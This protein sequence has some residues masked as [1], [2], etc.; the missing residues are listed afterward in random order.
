MTQEPHR[1]QHYD[2]CIVGA[3]IGGLNALY[4]A[5][6]YLRP[7]QRV[8]LVD[9]NE[10]VGGMWVNT[11]DYVRLHQP[12]PFFTTG[13]VQWTLGKEPAHLASKP[14]V[15]DHF[16]HCVAEARK[17][18]GVD[19]LLGHEM[20]SIEEVGD[21]V[22]VSCRVLADGSRVT[23][24]ADKVINAMALDIEA[25]Q[26]LALSSTHVHSVSPET[27]DMVA[28]PI[29]QD[30]APVWVIGS[31]KTAMDTA[32]ALITAQPGREV[33]L[34]AGTGT[35]FLERD[36]FYPVGRNRWWKGTRPN[37]LLVGVT[38]RLDGHNELE[39]FGWVRDT[40][41][42]CA[43]PMGEHF[44]LGVLSRSETDRIRNGL[45]RV[46]MGHLEDVVDDH[47]AVRLRLRS[48][49]QVTI[50]DGSW[51]VNC[52]SHFKHRPER[53]HVPYV[54]ES[55]R[56]VTLGI[57]AMFGFSSFAGYF[58]THLL[59]TGK[60][61]EVPLY[62]VDANALMARSAPALVASALLQSQYNLGLAFDALPAKVFQHFGLDFDRWYP[63]P[64]RLVGQVQFMVRHKK[65]REQY[66]RALDT[67]VARWDV[68][69]G[70]VVGGDQRA[71]PHS[72]AA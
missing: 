38:D 12:H 50:A 22:Q 52:T 4:V 49:E 63:L 30:S 29:S 3:G 23:I 27:C 41:G 24:T 40:V 10:R 33:N 66:R 1:P 59:Y 17:G 57:S 37:A 53:V 67:L 36:R 9:R 44:F 62:Q 20:E 14:E 60:I 6:Q 71:E 56:V 21:V 28:G 8:A 35:F 54:S 69:G 15:L 65:Q 42:T 18:V 5:S 13:D 16:A 31:G 39:V 51:V 43:L 19:E 32:L 11:Y 58:L 64:R 61:T 7:D 72:R 26:P 25:L 46:V 47:G 68:T 55:G 48:G 70:P 45:G 34:V 2:L